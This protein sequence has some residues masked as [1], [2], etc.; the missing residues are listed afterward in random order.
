MSELQATP[1]VPGRVRGILQRGPGTASSG[2][3][4]LLEQSELA[5]LETVPAGLIVVD[6]APL[7]HPLIRLLTLGIPAVLVSSAIADRLQ[8]GREVM[9]D[10][11]TGTIMQPAPPETAVTPSPEPPRPGEAI[12][13]SDGTK[14]ELRASIMGIDDAR[15]AVSNGAAAIGLMRTEFLAPDDGRAPDTDF[16]RKRLEQLCEAARPLAVTLRLPDITQDK[17]V[18][19]LELPAP[20]NTPLGLQGVRLFDIEPVRSVVDALLE[21]IK[22]LADTCPVKLL[23]PYVTRTDELLRWRDIID[24][25]LHGSVPVGAMAESPAAVLAIPRWLEHADF[26]GIGCNDLMQCLFAADRDLYETRHYLDFCSPELY[27][28]L[29]LAADTAGTEI[30][31]VQLCG[32]LP[33]QPGVLP[34]LVGMGFRSFSVAPVMIPYLA[35]TAGDIDLASAQIKAGQICAAGDSDA[36]SALL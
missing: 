12:D 33:Q 9:I 36:V 20:M 25:R 32:L 8:T 15:R 1:Y 31:R 14:I 27:R 3:I 28:F 24:H 10:G 7:S 19:W 34:V 17:P 26:V 4:C 6:G 11:L 2:S 5:S 16:Y 13:L 29:K 21:A 30:D 18:P 22:M 35:R 23:L